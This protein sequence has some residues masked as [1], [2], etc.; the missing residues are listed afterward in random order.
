MWFMQFGLDVQELSLRTARQAHTADV[1]ALA[2]EGRFFY[3]V[4]GDPG[5]V[6]KVLGGSPA[7][8]TERVTADRVQWTDIITGLNIDFSK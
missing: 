3:L 5:I 4:G 6:P 7:K 2:A 1:V 8:M